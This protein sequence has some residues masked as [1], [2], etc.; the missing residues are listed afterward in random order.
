MCSSRADPLTATPRTAQAPN[1]G[2]SVTPDCPALERGF[3]IFVMLAFFAEPDET[4]QVQVLLETLRVHNDE[5]AAS[6]DLA[7]QQRKLIND[8]LAQQLNRDTE[9]SSTC[10]KLV[11]RALSLSHNAT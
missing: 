4:R 9:I 6:V 10:H 7:R 11:Y 3:F 5:H 8:S 1:L 2:C